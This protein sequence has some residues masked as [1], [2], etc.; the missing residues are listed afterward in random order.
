M[1]FKGWPRPPPATGRHPRVR[2]TPTVLLAESGKC[3]GS[4]DSIPGHRTSCD[5]RTRFHAPTL[6]HGPWPATL[7]ASR[8]PLHAFFPCHSS[9]V[10]STIFPARHP[11]RTC[12]ERVGARGGRLGCGEAQMSIVDAET[13]G[14]TYKALRQRDGKI[15]ECVGLTLGNSLLRNPPIFFRMFTRV[16]L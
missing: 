15:V 14:Q 2:S 7:H 1:Y 10:S 5:H 9:L 4:G 8:G 12:E 13:G 11:E 6:P 16:R 3:Q